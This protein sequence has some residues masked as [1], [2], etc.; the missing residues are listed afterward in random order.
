[1][2]RQIDGERQTDIAKTDD[3][4]SNVGQLWQFHSAVGPRSADLRGRGRLRPRVVSRC[5][6]R[7]PELAETREKAEFFAATALDK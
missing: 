3:A 1:M 4:N 2:P 6:E 5:R 7:S